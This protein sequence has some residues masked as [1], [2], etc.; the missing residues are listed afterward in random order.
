MYLYSVSRQDNINT[1][2]VKLYCLLKR[3]YLNCK[4]SVCAESGLGQF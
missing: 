2:R 4:I 1:V 3:I